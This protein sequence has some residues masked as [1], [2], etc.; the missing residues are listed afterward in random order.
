M[1]AT[2]DA[3]PPA[4][5]GMVLIPAGSFQMG[6]TFKEGDSDEIPVHTVFVSAVYMDKTEVTKAL[7]DEVKGWSVG[8]GYGYDNPGAGNAANH[9]VQTVNWYDVV[10]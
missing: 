5:T 9:P 4:P 7:W 6:D 3:V 8:N 10:I 1:S 2:D